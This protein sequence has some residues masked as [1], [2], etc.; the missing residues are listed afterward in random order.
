MVASGTDRPGISA[1]YY[2]QGE[3]GRDRCPPTQVLVSIAGPRQ[4]DDE[5]LAYPLTLAADKPKRRP[6]HLPQPE[7]ARGGNLQLLESL[8]QPAVVEGRYFDILAANRERLVVSGAP[9]LHVVIYRGVR[10]A[11]EGDKLSSLAGG[12]GTQL[13]PVGFLRS[14]QPKVNFARWAERCRCRTV[15]DT[16]VSF[17]TGAPTAGAR[18]F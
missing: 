9:G 6:P 10:G 4:L 11:P 14:A 15:Q 17:S 16:G 18:R 3:R 13:P 5:T 7:F 1:D 2:L 8:S 12:V